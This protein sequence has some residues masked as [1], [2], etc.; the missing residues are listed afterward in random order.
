[1]KTRAMLVVGGA[2]GYVLGARAGR[3]RYETIKLQAQRLWTNPTVQQK[4][5]EAQD[6]A[7]EKAAQATDLAK[8]KAPEL[9]HKL[10]EATASVTSTVADKVGRNHDEQPGTSGSQ[11]PPVPGGAHG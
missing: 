5:S 10:A 9:Q 11:Y 8:E 4:A 2:I 3:E 7:R 1:M 6:L